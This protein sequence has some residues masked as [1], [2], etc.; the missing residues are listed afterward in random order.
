[1]TELTID[2]LLPEAPPSA[3]VLKIINA[4]SVRFFYYG[5][6]QFFPWTIVLADS[7]QWEI[8]KS[9]DLGYYRFVCKNRANLLR[10]KIFKL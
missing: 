5:G 1:M 7:R 2:I 10:I 3:F 6:E 4:R 9:F 8:M